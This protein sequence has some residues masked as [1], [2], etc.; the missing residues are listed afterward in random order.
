MNKCEDF[1]RIPLNDVKLQYS[2]EG[3]GGGADRTVLARIYTPKQVPG[4]LYSLCEAI[5]KGTVYPELDQPY[6]AKGCCKPG[7]D[8]ESILPGTEVLS[9]IST[10]CDDSEECDKYD[11]YDK[12]DLKKSKTVKGVDYRGAYK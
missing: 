7:A 11:G 1:M 6:G 10:K 2:G 4:E 9:G 8:G 3:L 12:C 5:D